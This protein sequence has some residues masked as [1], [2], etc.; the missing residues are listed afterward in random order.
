[1]LLS[2]FSSAADQTVTV[3]LLSSILSMV[4]LVFKYILIPF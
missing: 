3:K 4:L 2:N 1:M